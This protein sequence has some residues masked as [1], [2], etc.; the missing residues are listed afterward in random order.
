MTVT[1]LLQQLVAD[2]ALNGQRFSRLNKFKTTIC[3]KSPHPIVL[4]IEQRWIK[5]EG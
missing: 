3:S 5:Q 1:S 2:A 4:Q